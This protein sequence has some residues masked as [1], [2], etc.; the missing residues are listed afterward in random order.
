MEENSLKSESALQTSAVS[1]A[2]ALVLDEMAKTGLLYGRK[3]SKT[4]P[5][6]KRYIYGT[7]NTIEIF[8]LS[9]VL[10]AAEK[11]QEFLKECVK[12]GGLAL[13]VGTHPAAKSLIKDFA[14]KFN[15]PYVAERWLGGTL[16]NFKTLSGRI[17]YYLK[18]KKD[19]EAGTFEKYTKKERLDIDRE[20]E[21]LTINFSGL[22]NLKKP[23][24]ALIV[25]DTN[26]HDTAI[27]EAKRLGI[28]VIALIN[29]DADPENIT[30]PIPCNTNA[31]SAIEWVFKKFE[32]AIE[33]AQKEKPII[34][35]KKENV[36]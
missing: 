22:E 24:D 11:A 13:V 8:D 17:A 2:D 21:K 5:R 20:I 35:P 3:K 36:K 33:A 28:P 6:M 30:Y 27:R 18:L 7:R 26:I 25:I 1:A 15:F 4:H 16:T 34:E 29:S 19:R 31:K 9:K 10:A 23:A 14:T 32:I 12:K